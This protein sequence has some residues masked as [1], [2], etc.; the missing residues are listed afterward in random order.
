VAWVAE[1]KDVLSSTFWLLTMWA[2]VGYTRHRTTR[3]YATV[4][5]MFTLGLM[6][7]PMIV[8]L[9][10]ALLLLDYWPLER[11]APGGTVAAP[12]ARER[13]GARPWTALVVEKVPLFLLAL[14]AS[15]VTFTAQREVGAVNALTAIPLPLRL[16]NA[17]M[18]YIAY[19]RDLVLP[20]GLAALYPYP[21]DIPSLWIALA[22]GLC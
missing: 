4:I 11:S 17:M 7:K 5:V 3:S 2:Y 10:F 9:P 13:G 16:A 15:M 6:A 1:R 20:T 22:A 14:L 18:T 12:R 19:M 21:S 8:T